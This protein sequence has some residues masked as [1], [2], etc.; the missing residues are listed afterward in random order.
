MKNLVLLIFLAIISIHVSGQ[1]SL[2]LEGDSINNTDT[3]TWLGVNIPRSEPTLLTFRNNSITSANSLGYLLQAGDEGP[4]PSNN[5]LDRQLI[6]GNKLV[7]NG[8][9]A[10]TVITHG[11]FTGYNINSTLKYNYVDQVPYGILFKSGTDSG[12]NMTFTSGGCAYN[13]CR[14]GKFAVTMKGINGVKVY[15]NTFYNG[16]GSGWYFIIITANYDR[17]V[18]SPSTGSAIFN[19][20]FYSTI[21]NPMIS[22]ES[23]CLTGFEC[24]YNV[25]WCTA[26]EP[27]FSI[28][29]VNTSWN[30]WRALGFDA[31][32]RIADPEFID[33]THLVPVARLD[34][35]INL[36]TEW[37]TGLS[38]TADWIAGISPDTTI[39]NGAWQ[40]GARVYNE[41]IPVEAINITG[42]GGADSINT[43]KG[44]LQLTAEV[45]PG[46]ATNKTVTWAIIPGTGQASIS[47]SG[48]VTAVDNGTITATATANDG[49]GAYGSLLITISN[50]GTL[51]SNFNES[52][53]GNQS[54]FAFIAGDQLKVMVSHDFISYKANIYNLQGKLLSQKIVESDSLTFDI[55]EIPSG[56]YILELSKGLN[57]KGIKILK[58]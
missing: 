17:P 13:I 8:I 34:Y 2:L 31:H 14:N 46:N 55:S 3:G 5:N 51:S 29:G 25:Y 32:S 50:Q 47:E 19:N 40:V 10:D 38:T 44:T 36:G 22:I 45:I 26:G 39:Q 54:L 20:I 42:E 28:D 30:E 6:T 41:S 7:W 18:N 24:D 37:Q 4:Y 35:G 48:M 15:N 33:T 53:K 57:K 56:V 11:L 58:P 49:S 1:I 23:G 27:I 21:S 43:Y 16:D 52:S 12:E 9:K